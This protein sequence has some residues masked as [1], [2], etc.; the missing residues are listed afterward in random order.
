MELNDFLDILRGKKGVARRPVNILQVDDIHQIR[1]LKMQSAAAFAHRPVVPLEYVPI[2]DE[3]VAAVHIEDDSL[4]RSGGM[5]GGLAIIDWSQ[6]EPAD[7]RVF[8][9]YH[10][11]RYKMRLRS[12]N[13]WVANSLHP[14]DAWPPIPLADAEII[15][16]VIRFLTN[17]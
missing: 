7:G 3:N 11:G 17:L 16:R 5:P 1:A 6:R 8:L 4:S 15:A 14:P 12:P 9:I 2:E 13:Q 10:E